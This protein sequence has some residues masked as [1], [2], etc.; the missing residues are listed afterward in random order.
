MSQYFRTI[1]SNASIKQAHADSMVCISK[2]IGLFAVVLTKSCAG[3]SYCYF[4]ASN[5]RLKEASILC[6]FAEAMRH[7]LKAVSSGGDSH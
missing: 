5:F 3:S 6:S 2:V 1:V 7:R 4:P